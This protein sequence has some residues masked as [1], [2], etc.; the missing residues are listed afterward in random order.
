MLIHTKPTVTILAVNVIE[1][2]KALW[3]E[4]VSS[5]GINGEILCVKESNFSIGFYQAQNEQQ[6]IIHYSHQ[7]I[8]SLI[9]AME[10][11]MKLPILCQSLSTIK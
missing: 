6:P 11:D 4:S 2:P 3:M 8:F 10:L 5:A 1:L 7:T 9:Y